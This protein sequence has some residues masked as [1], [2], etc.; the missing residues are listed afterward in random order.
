VY[1]VFRAVRDARCADDTP[2][3]YCLSHSACAPSAVNSAEIPGGTGPAKIAAA[4]PCVSA[5]LWVY[6]PERTYNVTSSD[7][8]CYIQFRENE[9]RMK[10]HWPARVRPLRS[11]AASSSRGLAKSD[12][13]PFGSTLAFL[14]DEVHVGSRVLHVRSRVS[15][16]LPKS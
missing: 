4:M 11:F 10:C 3:I 1:G 9:L 2:H 5:V 14:N 6:K 16:G 15:P 8:T 12:L 7:D 13:H